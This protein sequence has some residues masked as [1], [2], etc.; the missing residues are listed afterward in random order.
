MASGDTSPAGDPARPRPRV[1]LRRALGVLAVLLL[2]RVVVWAVPKTIDARRLRDR[3]V[4]WGRWAIRNTTDVAIRELDIDLGLAGTLRLDYRDVLVEPSNIEFERPLFEAD[5]IRISLPAWGLFGAPVEPTLLVEDADVRVAR[6]AHGAYNLDGLTAYRDPPEDLPRSPLRWIRADRA[7]GSIQSSRLLLSFR[8]PEESLEIP[9]EGDLEAVPSGRRLRLALRPARFVF[10]SPGRPAGGT[11]GGF[12]LREA[13]LRVPGPPHVPP[14]ALEKLLVST[15]D[16]PVTLLHRVAPRLPPFPAESSFS[17]EVAFADREVRVAG[18]LR[19]VRIPLFDIEGALSLNARTR[20]PE[21]E[22]NGR[23]LHLES[24]TASG[25]AVRL[26]AV[27]GPEHR[28]SGL[29]AFTARLDLDSATPARRAGPIADWLDATFAT[30][31]DLEVRADRVRFRDVAVDSARILL[32]PLGGGAV[33]ARLHGNLA[34]GFFTAEAPAWDLR[35]ER[36]PPRYVIALDNADAAAMMRLLSDELPPL[37]RLGPS[38]G[39]LALEVVGAPPDGPE[40]AVQTIRATLTNTAFPLDAAGSFVAEI[41]RIREGLEALDE[42]RR[43]ALGGGG[44]PLPE[45][46]D[47][48]GSIRFSILTVVYERFA[49]GTARA[50]LSGLSPE[51]GELRGGGRFAGDG[52]FRVALSLRRTPA[53][54]MDTLLQGLPG[55][56]AEAVR[57][58][59]RAPEGLRIDLTSREDGQ[60]GV[61]FDRRYVKDIFRRWIEGRFRGD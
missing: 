61:A 16:F 14:V 24:R 48:P 53:P 31:P 9:L 17:G 54:F 58:Q 46:R 44:D 12:H 19:N 45:F 34:E 3:T 18:M 21:S 43:K 40:A 6:N 15:E 26:T 20:F 50:R 37:A 11:T 42:L 35:A 47:L 5:R 59:W 56:L 36:N 39:A 13:A 28:W 49:D 60:S 8:D 57:E 30:F 38:A 27:G 41:A 2:Y 29:L 33:R 7:A 55:D 32:A 25:E 4:E 22:T 51:I 23:S 10:S 52:T 1:W